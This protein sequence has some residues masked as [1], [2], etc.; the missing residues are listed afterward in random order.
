MKLIFND[1][2]QNALS[3]N[4]CTESIRK[5]TDG[6]MVRELSANVA[7]T[8]DR[9]QSVVASLVIAKIEIKSDD[10]ANLLL[11]TTRY[12]DFLAIN[13]NINPLATNTYIV[14]REVI[15]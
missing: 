6:V 15:V 4:E 7:E 14:F 2:V 10:G 13:N 1:D 5:D 9:L 12:K 11:S 8:L 3:V